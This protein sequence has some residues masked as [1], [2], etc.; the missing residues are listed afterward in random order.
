MAPDRA[1]TGREARAS[2]T[3]GDPEPRREEGQQAA[4][5]RELTPTPPQPVRPT[6][7]QAVT[8]GWG[9]TATGDPCTSMARPLHIVH[10]NWILTAG[11]H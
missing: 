8:W 6:T 3:Q 4:L 10:N 1:D 9:P 5:T 11:S 2:Q 7:L